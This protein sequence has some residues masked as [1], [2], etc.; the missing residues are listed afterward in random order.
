MGTVVRFANISKQ[1][2]IGQTRTSLLQ[3]LRNALSLGGGKIQNDQV[4][5]AL[6][7]VSFEVA[8]GETLGLV[9]SNGAGKTTILKVLANITHPTSG[10]VEI[11]GRLSALIEL[12][13][14]FHED[15]TGRENIY[16]NGTIL[17]LSRKELR[18]RFDEIVDFSEIE[19]FIDT[20]V[21]R[22]SSGMKV[23]L[24]FAVA[25][26][27]QPDV[28]LVD[29]VLAVGDAAFRQ[30]CMK[31]IQSLRQNGT[32]I[33]FVSHNLYMVQAVC[34]SALHIAHGQ[35]S[36][37]GLASEVIDQYEREVHEQRARQYELMQSEQSEPAGGVDI[38]K[39]EVMDMAGKRVV[40]FLSDQ[41][42]EIQVHYIAHE[43]IER[44][45]AVV[46]IVRSRPRHR[47]K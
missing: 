10:H 9:G 45:N 37:R 31:R 13:A 2:R 35:I 11:N 6:R 15:L 43:E 30:K 29:E 16:L 28:L 14:G 3:M 5:W 47:F 19:R 44:A 21:K 7:D 4:L 42:A 17:G 1:Y 46:R 38:T 23:R 20:P 22:Y 12:G 34:T 25:A 39:V 32:A 40:D 36:H 24:G 18:K 27:V 33:I 8:P 26:C 41:P